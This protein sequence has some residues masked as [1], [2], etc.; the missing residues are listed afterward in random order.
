V[1]DGQGVAA[2]GH[3]ESGGACADRDH[4]LTMVYA[5]VCRMVAQQ[6]APEQIL[7]SA[8]DALAGEDGVAL[9]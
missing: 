2:H 7:Q 9:V 1:D 4:R 5:R 3:A 8:C 6:H